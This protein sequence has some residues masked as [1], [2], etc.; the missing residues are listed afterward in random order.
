MDQAEEDALLA[1]ILAMAHEPT[2]N[3]DETQKS[4]RQTVQKA[5]QSLN[6]VNLAI[7]NGTLSG[8]EA[9]NALHEAE[10]QVTQARAQ[11]GASGPTP[12]VLVSTTSE[13]DITDKLPVMHDRD[14]RMREP[15]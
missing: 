12:D 9:D 13:S 15:L 11:L 4:A 7:L 3:E 10:E 5:E 6:E 2:D 1:A 14:A 8:S